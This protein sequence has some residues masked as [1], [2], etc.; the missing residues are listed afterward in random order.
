MVSEQEVCF[1]KHE[2][3]YPNKEGKNNGS[4]TVMH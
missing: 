1:C 4:L 3:I 2:E